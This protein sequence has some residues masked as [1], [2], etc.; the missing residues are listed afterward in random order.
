[1]HKPQMCSSVVAAENTL[2]SQLLTR[3]REEE[4]GGNCELTRQKE[5]WWEAHRERKMRTKSEGRTTPP[6]ISSKS[7]NPFGLSDST[8]AFNELLH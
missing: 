3:W 7:G 8:T 6:H 4:R 2:E 5:R 1:M